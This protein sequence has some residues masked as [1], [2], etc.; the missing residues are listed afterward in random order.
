MGNIASWQRNSLHNWV[1]L[2][3]VEDVYL[4]IFVA[5]KAVFLLSFRQLTTSSETNCVANFVARRVTFFI[6]SAVGRSSFTGVLL[7]MNGAHL[8]TSL[9]LNPKP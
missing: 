3:I 7:S 6:A 9:I 2:V 1:V 8:D 4:V 5:R